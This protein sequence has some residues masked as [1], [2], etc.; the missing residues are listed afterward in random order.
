M[1]I[2]TNHRDAPEQVLQ[3]SAQQD[4]WVMYLVVNQDA[5]VSLAELLLAATRAAMRCADEL[6]EHP[7]W[8]ESFRA[9]SER[10]FRK[11]TL[12]ARG[13]AWGK[14]QALEG[15]AGEARGVEVI[16]ALP[17]RLRSECG[18]LL[19]GL[20]VYNPEAASLPPEEPVE[21]APDHA[22]RF[23]FNPAARMSVGKQV[24]Q[25]AHAVLMCAGSA[26]AS[27]PRYEASFAAWR[28]GGYPGEI[29]P[30]SRWEALLRGADG[31]VVRDAGLT[32]VDPGT[33]T[34][35]ATPPGH[36]FASG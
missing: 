24:A 29:L 35:L 27:D 4:P 11:V 3:R 14:V 2:L 19:K 8:R 31:V 25:I 5:P 9:W 33:A 16:R 13:A 22:M 20:Q 21:P 30:S 12:R 34:V 26:W 36:A 6:G 28:G 10:S 23:V 7:A 32:E 15:G 18:A 1:P 17:P